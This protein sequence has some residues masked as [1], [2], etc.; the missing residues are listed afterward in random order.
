MLLQLLPIPSNSINNAF[1]CWEKLQCQ[2]FLLLNRNF[3]LLNLFLQTHTHTHTFLLFPYIFKG[4]SL[5]FSLE[6][7]TRGRQKVFK[8]YIKMPVFSLKLLGLI[9]MLSHHKKGDDIQ[10]KQEGCGAALC[11][12]QKKY[13]DEIINGALI[14]NF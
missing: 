1:P 4:I 7:E 12:H 6:G 11:N 10:I 8:K 5:N 3:S 9:V 14:M 2:N 13:Y